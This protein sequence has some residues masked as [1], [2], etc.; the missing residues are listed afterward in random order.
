MSIAPGEGQK[1]LS[2]MFDTDVKYLSYPDKLPFDKG[3]FNTERSTNITYRKYFNQ[4]FLNVDGRFSQDLDYLSMAQYRVEAKRQ[5]DDAHNYAW[6]QRP[7]DSANTA[8]QVRDPKCLNKFVRKDKAYRFM[9]NI[10][11]FPPYY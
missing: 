4:H 11:G 10:R 7:Y 9:K 8:A 3:G 5:L 1:P 2:M 6:C